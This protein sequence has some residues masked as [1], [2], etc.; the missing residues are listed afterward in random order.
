[1]LIYWMQ[2]PLDID[3]NFDSK[4]I[5]KKNLENKDSKW[6]H[7]TSI[8]FYIGFKGTFVLDCNTMVPV[9][10]IMHPGSPLDSQ[11]FS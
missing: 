1:M 5:S 6:G 10:F 9:L 2:P 8:G 11:I 7:G 4:K 3:Y